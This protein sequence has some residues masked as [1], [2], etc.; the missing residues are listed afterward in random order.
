MSSHYEDDYPE[1]D[2]EAPLIVDDEQ[3]SHSR[4]SS[5]ARRKAKR[6]RRREKERRSSH[7]ADDERKSKE[8]KNPYWI[9]MALVAVVFFVVTWSMYCFYMF[10]LVLSRFP[11][12]CVYIYFC[13]FCVTLL[14]ILLIAYSNI[15]HMTAPNI[16]RHSFVCRHIVCFGV[17]LHVAGCYVAHLWCEGGTYRRSRAL[18]SRHPHQ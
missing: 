8:V 12:A 18:P 9:R 17:S 1:G 7:D 2:E 5:R 14:N 16:V 10:G 13:T 3:G 15:K 6:K 4:G 11:L